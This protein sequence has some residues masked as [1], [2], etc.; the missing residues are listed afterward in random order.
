LWLLQARSITTLHPI[1]TRKIAAEVIPGIIR[2]LTWSINRPLTCGVW[3]EI[4]SLVLGKRAK[5]LDFEQTATLQFQRAYF[6]ATLLGEIFRRMGLPPE[7]LEF[8]TRGSKFTKPPLKS[9]LRNLPG[10]LRLLRRE[11]NLVRDFER[12][13]QRYFTP[14]LNLLSAL[15]R[16]Q[17]S[18]HDLLERVETILPVLKVA[19]YYSILAPLSLA[20]R[21]AILKVLPEQLDNSQTPEIAST[22]SLAELAT[23]ARNLLPIERL[24]GYSCPSLFAYMAE[25]PDGEGIL[26][27]F[28][29]WVDRYG[30]LSEVATDIAVPRWIEDPRPMRALFTRFLFHP[31]QE[32]ATP[33]QTSKNFSWWKVQL[34]QQRLNLK[35]QATEVYSRF[36]AYLRWTLIKLENLW[37]EDK[38]LSASGDIFFLEFS[39]IRRLIEATDDPLRQQLSQLIQQ[40]RAQY[41]QN[42]EITSVPYVVYGNPKAFSLP[43]ISPLLPKQRLQGVAA[44]P[45][46]V[47]GRVKIVRTLQQIT[48]IDSQT[49]LVVPYT[50]SGWTAILARAGGIIAE[51]G[52]SLSHGAIVAR[53]YGIPAVMD[54]HDATHLLKNG[55][56]VRIDGQRGIVEV[57]D[58]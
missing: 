49:I 54:I 57:L 7:S 11:W 4:F 58:K 33:N 32:R 18:P 16:S 12:D 40:R 36:L 13:E 56:R 19:T 24:S 52:G 8:L 2:P 26:V 28:E 47:E 9:S 34:V 14:T 22:R 39:E 10:L 35:G 42:Q 45:G 30:Y 41:Q 46:Q 20:L 5:G 43:T 23:Y 51:V 27:Q 21:Q 31:P 25:T 3:G 53:E 17:A 48:E 50:D 15:S 55:Q 1:W 29:Q 38:T 6:N 37:L 44:S